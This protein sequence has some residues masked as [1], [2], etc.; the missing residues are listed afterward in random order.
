MA[1][2]DG[3]EVG[4]GPLAPVNDEATGLPLLHLPEGFTYVSLGWAGDPMTNGLPTPGLHD[5][6]AAFPDRR[7]RIRLVRNHEQGAG[8]AF[9]GAYYD[10]R[11]LRRHDD[12]GIRSQA[13][14]ARSRRRDSLRGT[15][16]ELRRRPTPWNSWMTCEESTLFVDQ[17]HGYVFDV[18]AE[19]FSDATPIRDMGRLSHEVLAVDPATGYIYE[20]EECGQ[21]LGLLPLSPETALRP[22]RGGRL[23]MLKVKGQDLVNLGAG[24]ANGTSFRVEWAPIEQPDRSV[25]VDARRLRVGAGASSL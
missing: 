13:A 8:P 11:A 9:S 2:L 17:P 7:N 19:G 5:G 1:G 10:A 3:R 18:P 22:A 12:A 15:I 4:Y 20:N 21:Q 25:A 14:I 23:F 16:T 24:Y 6:M